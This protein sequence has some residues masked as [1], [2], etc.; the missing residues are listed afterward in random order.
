[1]RTSNSPLFQ[2]GETKPSHSLVEVIPTPNCM[3]HCTDHCNGLDHIGSGSAVSQV[4]IQMLS[5]PH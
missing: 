5:D 3:A 4:A 1:M 2:G